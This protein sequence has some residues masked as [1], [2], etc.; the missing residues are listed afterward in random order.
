M[1]DVEKYS[2]LVI[3]VRWYEMDGDWRNFLDVKYM[4]Q[5]KWME[6]LDVYGFIDFICVFQ[7]CYL[8]FCFKDGMY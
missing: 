5:L 7:V 2:L 1:N 3:W 8:I 4:C 6:G